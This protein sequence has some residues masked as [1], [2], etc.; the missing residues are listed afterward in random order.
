MKYSFIFPDVNKVQAVC[1]HWKNELFVAR[2]KGRV[3]LREYA[4]SIL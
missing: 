2:A 1:K 3:I 4:V